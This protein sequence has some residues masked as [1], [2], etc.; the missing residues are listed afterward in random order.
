MKL[1][2]LTIFPLNSSSKFLFVLGRRYFLINFSLYFSSEIL[3]TNLLWK[4]VLLF[5]FYFSSFSWTIPFHEMPASPPIVALQKLLHRQPEITMHF[6]S[7]HHVNSHRNL[8]HPI[9]HLIYHHLNLP[10]HL[11]LRLLPILGKFHICWQEDW[12]I[13]HAILTYACRLK[14]VSILQLNGYAWEIGAVHE[15]TCLGE[16]AFQWRIEKKF[17]TYNKT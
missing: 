6:N 15:G 2:L 8:H 4:H 11:M 13:Y 16:S 12:E 3:K 17:Q 9:L 10:E 1:G 14:I 7:L 5:S